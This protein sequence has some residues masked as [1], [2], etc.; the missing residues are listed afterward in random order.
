MS[1]ISTRV[2][3]DTV[4]GTPIDEIQTCVDTRVEINNDSKPKV[5]D[6][7]GDIAKFMKNIRLGY[8]IL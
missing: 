7:A 4:L 5:G 2:Y 3:F 6:S 8:K 1:E